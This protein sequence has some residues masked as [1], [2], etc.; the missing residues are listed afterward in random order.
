M[1]KADPNEIHT[2]FTLRDDFI[3]SDF[4]VFVFKTHRVLCIQ[5][6]IKYAYETLPSRTAWSE[7][8]KLLD[9]LEHK[10][11]ITFG[12]SCE[13]YDYL[14]EYDTELGRKGGLI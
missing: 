14:S 10:H 7:S 2:L 13:L 5:A 9:T 1:A 11:I 8:T 3:K 4:W 6:W 12:E